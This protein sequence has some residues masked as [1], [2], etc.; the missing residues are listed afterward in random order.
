[1]SSDNRRMPRRI[2]EDAVFLL[3][4]LALAYIEAM[5]PLGAIL[6]LPGFKP[7]LANILVMILVFRGSAADGAVVSFLRVLIMG[8]LFGSPISMFFSFGGALLSWGMLVLLKK[9]CRKHLT[10]IGISVLS[11]A[12]HNVG[13]L[14]CAGVVFDFRVVGSYLPFLL[15]ASAIFGAVSGFLVNALYPHLEKLPFGGRK[16]E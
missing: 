1:M 6:P 9:S 7:G 15:F 16:H 8:L 14:I 2:A 5:I 3:L 10:F 4:A 13:Q 12:A 11:A